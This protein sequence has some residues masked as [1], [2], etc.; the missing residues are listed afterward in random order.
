VSQPEG[1]DN[2][3][4][5]L[6][7]P[8]LW[9]VDPAGAYWARRTPEPDGPAYR[10]GAVFGPG[11]PGGSRQATDEELGTMALWAP[12]LE[13]DEASLADVQHR[14]SP[15]LRQAADRLLAVGTVTFQ[16]DAHA[17]RARIVRFWRSDSLLE[18][19]TRS[20]HGEGASRTRIPR[21]PEPDL[22]VDYLARAASEG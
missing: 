18:T 16:L 11:V 7:W 22:L 14:W 4:V 10:G 21:R 2:S 1:Y 3:G 13:D 17:V 15:E 20:A 6:P 19:E 9:L 5:K 8:L 12:P